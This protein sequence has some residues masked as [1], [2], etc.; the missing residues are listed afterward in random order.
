VTYQELLSGIVARLPTDIENK[1]EA[2]QKHIELTF[3]L[4]KHL[5]VNRMQIA[6]I[7]ERSCMIY[8]GGDRKSDDFKQSHYRLTL[9]NFCKETELVYT[10]VNTWI[11][12]KNR[13]F[14]YLPAHLQDQ[15]FNLTAAKETGEFFKS[16]GYFD[17]EQKTP[18]P[19]EIVEQYERRSK[20]SE[21]KLRQVRIFK[22]L[23]AAHFYLVTRKNWTLFD[24]NERS[25]IRDFATD[26]MRSLHEYESITKS[27]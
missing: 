6:E 5:E 11:L 24:E 22:Y 26:I 1:R 21:R 2:W 12:V 15:K 14:N 16:K 18:T 10:T 4:K 19:A 23:R 25:A 13:V 8:A 20:P 27:E 9:K 3:E 17:R 7:A